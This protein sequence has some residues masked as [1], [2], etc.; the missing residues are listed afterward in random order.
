MYAPTLPYSSLT[1]AIN[2]QPLIMQ[3]STGRGL[4][5]VKAGQ[6]GVAGHSTRLDSLWQEGAAKIRLPKS[7]STMP[8]AVLINTSGGLTGGDSLHWTAEAGD[9]TRLCITTQACEKLY[10]ATSDAPAAKVD[11]CLLLGAGAEVHWLPQETIVCNNSKIKRGLNVQLDETA[12]F[13]AIE[14]FVF[15]RQHMGEHITNT[16]ISDIWRIHRGNKLCHA[17]NFK[18]QGNV[19]HQLA[20]RS[21]INNLSACATIVYVGPECQDQLN[22]TVQSLKVKLGLTNAKAQMQ[23]FISVC[24]MPHKIVVRVLAQDSF[25]L[26]QKLRPLLEV[27][28]PELALPKYWSL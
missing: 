26:R 28:R 16:Q 9:R 18:L 19:V 14:S 12:R 15:G 24:A 11:S 20:G 10:A 4:V 7:Y 5:R 2:P 8:E 13:L 22:A 6:G 17:E 23:Q 25:R 1:P 3:R 27:L 21:L